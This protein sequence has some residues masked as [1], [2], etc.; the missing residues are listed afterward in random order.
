MIENVCFHLFLNFY[1]AK[2]SN[3][4]HIYGMFKKF[5]KYVF[6]YSNI[7]ILSTIIVIVVVVV[8]IYLF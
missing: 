3:K 4:N 6:Q 5:K 2:L 8:F 1:D 7:H